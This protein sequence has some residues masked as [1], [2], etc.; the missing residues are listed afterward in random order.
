MVP[1]VGPSEAADVGGDELARVTEGANGCELC[2]LE[3]VP[4]F[5]DEVAVVEQEAGVVG[6]GVERDLVPAVVGLRPVGC[7]PVL[8]ECGESFVFFA[9]EVLELG[10]GG[11]VEGLVGVLVA[12]LP[13]DDIGVVAEALRE[14]GGDADAEEAVM[15]AGVG[16]LAAV[17]MFAEWPLASVPRVSG[18]LVV[19]HAGG[20]SV[21]VPM[22]T[23]M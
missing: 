2:V 11:G 8:V 16:E 17:A 4:G 9:E 15:W 14:G 3:A 19:S 13:A 23:A 18:Y 6:A 21:G 1:I 5:G 7:G 12:D 20:A 22:T 10:A